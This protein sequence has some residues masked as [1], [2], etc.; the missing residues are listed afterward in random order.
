M[1]S[2]GFGQRDTTWRK[3]SYSINNGSCVEVAS[4]AEVIMVRD[5]TSWDALILS[6]S[7]QAWKAFVSEVKA[8]QLR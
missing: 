6:Y 7:A 5:S 3:S 2:P 4:A 8:G 1:P